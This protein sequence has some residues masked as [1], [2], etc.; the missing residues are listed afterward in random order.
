MSGPS[1]NPDEL[2]WA[3]QNAGRPPAAQKTTSESFAA[4][5]R[6]KELQHAQHKVQLEQ[7][8]QDR[9]FNKTIHAQDMAA[10]RAHHNALIGQYSLVDQVRSNLGSLNTSSVEWK[11]GFV[12][13]L[14]LGALLAGI[15]GSWKG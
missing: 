6:S 5:A 14:A 15:F 12:V 13:G 8:Q 2:A 7:Q 3:F 1:M 9:Q 4:K 11:S 10:A